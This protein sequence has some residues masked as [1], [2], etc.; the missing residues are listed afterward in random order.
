MAVAAKIQAQLQDLEAR[1]LDGGPRVRAVREAP[2]V[3]PGEPTALLD[4]GATHVV[5]DDAAAEPRT[6]CHAPC[7]LQVTSARLG[8]RPLEFP[9]WHRSLGTVMHHR[10]FFPSEAWLANW[11]A[12]YDGR[13]RPGCN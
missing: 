2:T 5:L 13:K 8:I 3:E 4:S 6:S 10:P 1:V 7:R 9:W 11:V 12:S